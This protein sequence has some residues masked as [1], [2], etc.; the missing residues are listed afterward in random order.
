VIFAESTHP[1]STAAKKPR[2]LRLYRGENVSIAYNPI[3]S[4]RP[5]RLR[6]VKETAGRIFVRFADLYG[7]IIDPKALGLSARSLDLKSIRVSADGTGADIRA[8][9]RWI[10]L[11]AAA[12]RARCD[13]VYASE[14]KGKMEELL[15][16]EMAERAADPSA[17]A[18]NITDDELRELASNNRPPRSW[19]HE[20]SVPF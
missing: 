15:R 3:A 12:L 19:Y 10:A 1:T 4:G 17:G 14:L 20:T 5:D 8:G 6:E 9:R 13:A 2:K 7:V 16:D 18:W 11:D